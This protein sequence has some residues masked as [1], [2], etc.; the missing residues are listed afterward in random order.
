[1]KEYISNTGIGKILLQSY[2]NEHRLDSIQR[3]ALVHLIIDGVMSRNRNITSQLAEEIAQEVIVEFPTETKQ[4][5]YYPAI[6][7]IKNSGGKLINRYRMY[8]NFYPK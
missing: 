5:Y 4:V 3:T 7:R 6:S 1:L 8:A 2:A